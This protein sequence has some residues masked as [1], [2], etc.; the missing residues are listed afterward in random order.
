MSLQSPA[1]IDV[2]AQITALLEQ[3]SA[4]QLRTVY[5]ILQQSFFTNGNRNSLSQTPASASDPIP[6]EEQPWRQYTTH[7]KPSPHWDE[8]LAAVAAARQEANDDEANNH[9]AI[10]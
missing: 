6:V 1:S 2:K 9:E 8:F 5:Q 10:A 7:L 4:E 3:L